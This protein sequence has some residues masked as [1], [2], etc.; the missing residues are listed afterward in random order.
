MHMLLERVKGSGKLT[1]YRFA[2]D[3]GT[4]SIGWAV[5]ELDAKT[6]K[7][8]GL[9]RVNKQGNALTASPL[10]VRIFEDGRSP[11]GKKSNAELRQ[12]P[13]SARRGHDRKLAR[14]AQ[15]M[16]DLEK[17]GWM[18]PEG[19]GRDA[20]FALDP[21]EIR[22]R[23]VREKVSLPELGRALWHM[24]KHRGFKSNRKTDKPEDDSGLIKAASTSLREKLRQEG[25][26]TYG[27]YLYSRVKQG[28]GTR[29]RPS[30]ENAEK[31]YD[32]YPTRDMLLDEFDAVW[33]EQAKHHEL[34]DSLRDRL[35]D[36]TI[37]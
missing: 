32:F 17:A 9:A 30:G 7:P 5:F 18:P 26:S 6:G 22:A 2:F 4:R 19:A 12:G 20:L 13:R 3:L 15:L 34:S 16:E 33:S 11:D 28:L 31:R 36:Y 21:Y 23:A 14:R 35:R 37:F 10:G 27:A 8:V 29:V 1:K 24:S 25:H